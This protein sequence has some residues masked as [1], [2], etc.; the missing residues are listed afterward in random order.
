MSQ[1]VW[2]S[3]LLWVL[4]RGARLSVRILIREI[5]LSCLE[6]VQDVTVSVALPVLP[7]FIQKLLSKCAALRCRKVM[8]L[9]SVRSS[10]CSA[11]R[12]SVRSLKSATTLVRA[13]FL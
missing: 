4:L 6:D 8:L 7:R 5:S 3:V 11:V 12:R 10:V 13:V 2:R 1:N 9:L